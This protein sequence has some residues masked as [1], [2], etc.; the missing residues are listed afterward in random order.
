MFRHYFVKVT[1]MLALTGGVLAQDQDDSQSPP[2]PPKIWAGSVGAGLSFTGG[3]TKTSTYN[4]S[5][6]LTRDPKTRNIMRF[7]GL[8]L[9]ADKDDEAIANRLNLAFRDEYTLSGNTFLYGDFGYLRDPFRSISY[10]LN[11][12]GGIGHKIVN[13]ERAVFS[14]SGGAGAVWE[15][16]PGLEVRS[17]GTVNAGQDLTFNIAEGTQLTQ[18][19]TALWKMQDFGDS[20]YQFNIALATTIFKQAQ[21][22]VEFIND[23]K[24]KPPTPDIKKNDTA[25]LTSFV[26]KF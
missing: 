4:F 22:K 23:Y 6:E 11:P 24:N 18:V 25:F 9:R 5:F 8:F 15:K 10:L 21:L 16:N 14:V 7:N 3:N 20:L 1:V 19:F 2:P 12:Q 26:Y 17:D 13:T